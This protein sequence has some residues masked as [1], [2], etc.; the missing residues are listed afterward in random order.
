MYRDEEVRSESK[1]QETGEDRQSPEYLSSPDPGRAA[2]CVGER[3]ACSHVKH[4]AIRARQAFSGPRRRSAGP[5]VGAWFMS[6]LSYPSP[7]YTSDLAVAAPRIA[8]CWRGV[9]S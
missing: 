2:S 8:P 3:E 7:M 6:A 9:P 1:G 5:A 4:R